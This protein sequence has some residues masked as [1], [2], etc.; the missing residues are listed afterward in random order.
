MLVLV[1][2]TIPVGL[3]L[4]F[5]HIVRLLEY[6]T[7]HD[8]LYILLNGGNVMCLFNIALQILPKKCFKY[9]ANISSGNTSKSS[10]I[11]F[12]Q[13]HSEESKRER[14]RWKYRRI[15]NDKE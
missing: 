2:A 9:P 12:A 13:S 6:C 4:S 15:Y 1:Q 10:L 11:L 5:E 3:Q 7:C 8:L 14:E